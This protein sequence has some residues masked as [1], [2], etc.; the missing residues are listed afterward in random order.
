MYENTPKPKINLNDIILTPV[1]PTETDVPK[2]PN[3][4]SKSATQE[5]YLENNDRNAQAC[6]R[7]GGVTMPF[8]GYECCTKPFCKCEYQNP[9]KNNIKKCGLKYKV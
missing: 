2:K 9:Y 1:S 8:E 3:T 7:N 5:I 6:Q 4:R